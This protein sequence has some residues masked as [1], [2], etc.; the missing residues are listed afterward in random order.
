MT[1]IAHKYD[2]DSLCKTFKLHAEMADERIK[3]FPEQD[4]FNICWALLAICEAIRELH[5]EKV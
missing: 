1:K 5:R 4:N 3:G 2:I